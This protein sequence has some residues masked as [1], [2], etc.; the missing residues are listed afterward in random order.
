MSV[1]L[2]TLQIEWT[3]RIA[4]NKLKNLQRFIGVN[5]FHHKCEGFYTDFLKVLG[6]PIELRVLPYH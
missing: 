6:K 2:Q 3:I 5:I 1:R 4:Q